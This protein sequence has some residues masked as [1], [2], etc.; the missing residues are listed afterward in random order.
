MGKP[1]RKTTETNL[2]LDR[3]NTSKLLQFKIEINS[4]EWSTVWKQTHF[5]YFI[6]ISKL[7]MW[8]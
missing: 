5:I 1:S 2:K 7:I 6:N 3:W 4:I 8:V